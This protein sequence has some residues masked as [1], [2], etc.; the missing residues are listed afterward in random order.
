M[1]IKENNDRERA[2]TLATATASLQAHRRPRTEAEELAHRML[3]GAS[4]REAEAWEPGLVHEIEQKGEVA[5][6]QWL[7]RQEAAVHEVR[8]QALE[9][10]AAAIRAKRAA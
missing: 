3:I 2:D 5:G 4:T 9:D 6:R 7:E 8:K 1:I 10:Y